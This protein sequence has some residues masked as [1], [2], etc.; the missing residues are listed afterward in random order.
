MGFSGSRTNASGDR[1]VEQAAGVDLGDDHLAA[2]FLNLLLGGSRKLRSGHLE[3]T[4]DLSVTKD[5]Y[6]RLPGSKKAVLGEHRGGHILD[7]GGKSVEI[8]DIDD[9]DF[10]AV[11][12]VIKTPMRQLTIEGHLTTLETRANA[13]AGAGRLAFT[14]PAGCLASAA[15]F[16]ATDTLLAVHCTRYVFEFVEFHM[17][18]FWG[19]DSYKCEAADDSNYFKKG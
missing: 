1:S 15:A 18:P 9:R 8:T 2:G 11:V 4:P 7:S 16:A 5:L 14:S 3:G 6:Y 17:F 12:E 19:A 10:D 13:P